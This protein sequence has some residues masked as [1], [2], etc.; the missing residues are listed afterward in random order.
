MPPG[1]RRFYRYAFKTHPSGLPLSIIRSWY[2]HRASTWRDAKYALS[3]AAKLAQSF[4][5]ARRKRQLRVNAILKSLARRIYRFDDSLRQEYIETRHTR[6]CLNDSRDISKAREGHSENPAAGSSILDR[7][8]ICGI[9]RDHAS[10]RAILTSSSASFSMAVRDS[11]S[12]RL[13]TAIAKNTFKRI[14]A[15]LSSSRID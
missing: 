10:I 13:S 12:A 4:M 9:I 15:L 8:G 1:C 2:L 5:E 14:S 6:D 7:T 11:A 3:H